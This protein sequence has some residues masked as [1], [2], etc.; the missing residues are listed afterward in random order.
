MFDVGPVKDDG[1]GS[2]EDELDPLVKLLLE[3][4][5]RRMLQR[6]GARGTSGVL[7]G[8]GIAW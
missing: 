5:I 8:D 2:V 1:E 4:D 3:L 6:W 7:G